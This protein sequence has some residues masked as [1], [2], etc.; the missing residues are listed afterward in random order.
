MR[1][2]SQT[3][4]YLLILLNKNEEFKSNQ[5]NSSSSISNHIFKCK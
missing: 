4:E 5:M 3:L 1:V 2:D